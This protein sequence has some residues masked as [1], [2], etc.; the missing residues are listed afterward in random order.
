MYADNLVLWS[1]DE[2]ATTAK[3]R[4]QEEINIFVNWS[5]D[6]WVK[7]DKTKYFRTL[8]TYQ[9]NQNP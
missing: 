1:I 9:P 3:I 6:W 2:Y 5:Q 4:L 7:I 8:F